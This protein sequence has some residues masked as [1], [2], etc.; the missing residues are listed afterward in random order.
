MHGL[1]Q[2]VQDVTPRLPAAI[3]PI[4][5]PMGLERSKVAERE[6]KGDPDSLQE[7]SA[8]SQDETY[9]FFVRPLGAVGAVGLELVVGQPQQGATDLNIGTVDIFTTADAL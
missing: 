1:E 6:V 9:L 8:G 4:R 3:C 5:N 2:V 7:G